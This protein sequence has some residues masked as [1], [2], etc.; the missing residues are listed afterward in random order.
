MPSGGGRRPVLR[1]RAGA[2]RSGSGVR[3]PSNPRRRRLA[4]DWETEGVP[5]G[6]YRVDVTVASTDLETV[7]S[8]GSSPDLVRVGP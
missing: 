2:A 6:D 1:S 7:Y 3:M 8:R 4:L 5:R